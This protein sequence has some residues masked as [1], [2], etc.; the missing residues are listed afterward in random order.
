M[1]SKCQKR[2]LLG[3][4]DAA[5]KWVHSARTTS[6]LGGCDGSTLVTALK[7][8]SPSGQLMDSRIFISYSLRK[9]GAPFAG[10]AD[11]RE[12]FR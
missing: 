2:T 5:S 7:P 4:S 10:K 8:S 9:D 1:A 11:G 3:G 12:P 6:Y